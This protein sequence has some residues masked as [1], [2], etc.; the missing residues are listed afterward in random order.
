MSDLSRLQG[1]RAEA[2]ADLARAT[3]DI[4]ELKPKR[5]P[6]MVAIRNSPTTK[7]LTALKK[8]E[9]QIAAASVTH[10]Q[11]IAEIDEIDKKT[12]PLE[13]EAEYQ[14]VMSATK[15]LA[16]IMDDQRVPLARLIGEDVDAL[17]GH[18]EEWN[19]LSTSA[20]REAHDIGFTDSDQR[21]LS[22]G[23]HINNWL[24]WRLGKF[25]GTD[26]MAS[27]RAYRV[28]LEEIEADFARLSGQS[29]ER[30][31]K[32]LRRRLNLPPQ[33]AETNSNGT[34]STTKGEDND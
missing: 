21:M 32:K 14:P 6:L 4:E 34:P 2:E 22:K 25:L 27:H 18:L 10:D 20:G 28:P 17:E 11:H 1:Q 15:R 7:R 30:A 12:R 24:R 23:I 16:S 33:R 29:S 26:V 9:S 3:S 19:L 13:G 5:G 8:L 31:L